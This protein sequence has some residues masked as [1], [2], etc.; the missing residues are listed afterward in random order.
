MKKGCVSA[1][2]PFHLCDPICGFFYYCFICAPKQFVCMPP[3]PYIPDSIP[4]A[5]LSHLVKIACIFLHYLYTFCNTCATAI[6]M[7]KSI[8]IL[9]KPKSLTCFPDN[10]HPYRGILPT[11]I[12]MAHILTQG[13]T[14]NKYM[15]KYPC[16]HYLAHNSNI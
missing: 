3:T 4:A 9:Q 8:C 16:P 14:R 6:S 5:I 13:K 10:S 15:S 7:R 1:Q 2:P 12:R 11:D